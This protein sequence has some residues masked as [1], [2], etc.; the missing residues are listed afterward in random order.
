MSKNYNLTWLK[1]GLVGLLMCGGLFLI[2]FL[3]IPQKQDYGQNNASEAVYEVENAQNDTSEVLYEVEDVLDD[4]TFTI[5][6]DGKVTSVRIIGVATP[7]A[8]SQTTATEDFEKETS[9]YLETLLAGKKV[10]IE[11]DAYIG[12][13]DENGRLLR[14]VYLDGEDI[15]YRI[16]TDGYAYGY[17]YENGDT[18]SKQTIYQ[19]AQKEAEENMSGLWA[20]SVYSNEAGKN[21][22]NYLEDENENESVGN[23]NYV[24]KTT[25]K[26]CTIKGNI[27]FSGEKIYHVPG[28][29]YYDSTIINEKYGERWFC[30]EAEAQ[31]A[32]WRKSK[33]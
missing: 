9:D 33:V 17:E 25:Q 1:A 22:E 5:E 16:I 30:S 31:A 7:E 15:G 19:A 12:E 13:T 10:Q 4:Y 21:I 27:T 18:Y 6:Y 23:T 26:T 32:G 29:K 20:V 8:I 14:Y 11:T 24:E 3:L 28:Q 2:I